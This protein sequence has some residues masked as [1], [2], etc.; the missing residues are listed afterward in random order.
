M[1]FL[2]NFAVELKAANYSIKES[3][4]KSLESHIFT[5]LKKD[6]ADYIPKLPP[7]DI[8]EAVQHIC[9]SHFE[10]RHRDAYIG[11]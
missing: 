3:V 7:Y 10:H 9:L 4:L 1:Q 2:Y 5:L 11:R 8:I 6:T